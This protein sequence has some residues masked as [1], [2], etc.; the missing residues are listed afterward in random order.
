M[1]AVLAVLAA[2]RLGFTL[3][4]LAGLPLVIAFAWGAILDARTHRIPNWLTLP[5]LV[6][7]L[8]AS[9]LPD[10]WRPGDAAVGALVCGGILLVLALLS[11]G[12]IGGADVKLA[13]V[14]GAGV[15]PAIGLW[16]LAFAHAGAA[17]VLL[18]SFLRGRRKLREP[19]AFGPFL[20]LA[21][22]LALLLG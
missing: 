8:G 3:R 22:I 9:F 20:A 2:V 18:P 21:G 19:V 5:A 13:A 15:G 6:W 4:G 14:M 10:R 1:F 12:A 17:I 7:A 16:A 11:R